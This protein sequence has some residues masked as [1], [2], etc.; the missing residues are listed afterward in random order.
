VV[1]TLASPLNAFKIVN[2]TETVGS[3]TDDRA[4]AIM[5]RFGV[6]APMIPVAEEV[7]GATGKPRTMHFE[8][9]DDRQLTPNTMLVSVYQALQGTNAAGANQSYRLSGEVAIAGQPPVALHGMMSPNSMNTGAINAA[10]YVGERFDRLYQNAEE[11]PDTPARPVI[12][13]LMLHVAIAPERRTA[14]LES[15]RLSRTEARAGETIA[16]EVTL[17]AYQAEP[18]VLRLQVQLPATLTPG[19]L[20]L[21]LSDGATL[22]RLATPGSAAARAVSLTDTV[23]AM[24]RAHANDRVYATLL[25]RAPQALLQAG[26]LRQI[27]LSMANVLEPLKDNQQVQ[28]TGESVVERGSAEADVAVSGSQVLRLVIR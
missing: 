9:L 15:A 10:L 27:P 18:K 17:R 5:C 22:D 16:V 12:T 6:E 7:A 26:A 2:T 28:L 24:N 4:S 20:R 19:P 3:F 11:Q 13:G 14:V 25:D 23:A 21:L 1:A 8:V